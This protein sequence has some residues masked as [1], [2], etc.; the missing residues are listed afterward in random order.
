MPTS[1]FHRSGTTARAAVLLLVGLLLA[2]AAPASA[3]PGKGA[4]PA[5]AQAD[6]ELTV[7]TRNLYLGAELGPI[8]D[9]ASGPELLL[10]ATTTYGAALASDFPGR[11]ELL[12]DEIVTHAPDLVGLQEAS[13]WRV[14]AFGADPENL[15]PAETVTQDF[16]AILLDALA[17][18]GASYEPVSVVEAFDG[19]LPAAA[20]PTGP[21]FNVRLTDRDVILARTDL[22]TSRLKVQASDAG[23]FDTALPLDVLGDPLPVVRGWTSVDVKVRGKEVRFV[24]SHL[25]AFGGEF[26][27]NLQAMELLAG[28]LD[29]ELPV[30]LLGDFNSPAPSGQTYQ[31]LLSGGFTDVWSVANP[32]DPGLTC[33][34]RGDLLNPPDEDVPE[35]ERE[36]DK[37]IDLIL[38]R[39]GIGVR[40]ATLIG[41]DG[42]HRTPEGRWPSDHAGVVATL[43]IPVR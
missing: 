38:T 42:D 13:L 20:G 35:D 34:H 23:L 11:A 15:A 19:Q 17:A 29:T 4:P 32:D 39:G 1:A 24:N 43:T 18:R 2:T 31:T 3:V 14:G 21:F 40:D 27:R 28:P 26:F 33:C 41:V 12:A 37:R 8:F 25:E 7:M 9:A 10:A 22:A 5:Q 16:L 36:F 6:R 30:I